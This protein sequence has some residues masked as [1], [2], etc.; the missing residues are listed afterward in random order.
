MGA[1]AWRTRIMRISP[2]ASLTFSH[3]SGEINLMVLNTLLGRTKALFVANQC[4]FR[5]SLSTVSNDFRTFGAD[6]LRLR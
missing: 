5:I 3:S 1:R 6:F 2:K 4:S